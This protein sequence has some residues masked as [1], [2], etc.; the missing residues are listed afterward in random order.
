MKY[1]KNYIFTSKLF[2]HKYYEKKNNCILSTG[3]N[4]INVTKLYCTESSEQE[5]VAEM[6]NDL[7]KLNSGVIGSHDVTEDEEEDV[8]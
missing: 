3:I 4:H 5:V 7:N 2:K 8:N 1:E 6:E